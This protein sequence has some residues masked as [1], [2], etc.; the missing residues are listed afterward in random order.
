MSLY[1]TVR[2][3][4]K[5]AYPRFI[6]IPTKRSKQ[7]DSIALFVA[8]YTNSLPGCQSETRTAREWVYI[9]F[10]QWTMSQT[11]QDSRRRSRWAVRPRGRRFA[12]KLLSFDSPMRAGP[13]KSFLASPSVVERAG[14]TAILLGKLRQPVEKGLGQRHAELVSDRRPHQAFEI[15]HKVG[16]RAGRLQHAARA[17]PRS[18][19]RLGYNAAR[20]NGA[21]SR[22]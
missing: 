1:L 14:T 4:I 22:W 6:S 10:S 3:A 11:A 7:R 5:E 13:R 2:L 18:T 15:E 21:A 20:H 9:Q 8:P 16:R 17:Q 19:F 12:G